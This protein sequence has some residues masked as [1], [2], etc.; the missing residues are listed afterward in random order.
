MGTVAEDREYWVLVSRAQLR[1]LQLSNSRANDEDLHSHNTSLD[2]IGLMALVVDVDEL[3]RIVGHFL[4]I[5]FH[6]SLRRKKEG[7]SRY[8]SA[9]CLHMAPKEGADFRLEIWIGFGAGQAVSQLMSTGDDLRDVLG[10]YLFEVT[11]PPVQLTW[12]GVDCKLE[13]TLGFADGS[14]IYT[15]AFP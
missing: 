7:T 14:K 13:L 11:K 6:T 2:E 3:E 15:S 12:I 8:T 5:G 10:D 9:A 1:W 4:R